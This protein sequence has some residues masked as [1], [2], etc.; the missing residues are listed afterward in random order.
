MMTTGAAADRG[1]ARGSLPLDCRQSPAS[2]P[3]GP[4]CLASPSSTL[5]RSVTYQFRALRAGPLLFNMLGLF[6]FGSRPRGAPRRPANFLGLYFAKWRSGGLL[7]FVNFST[8]ELKE[9]SATD[10][11]YG[12]LNVGQGYD[13]QVCAADRRA[14]RRRSSGSSPGFAR[15]WP[16]SGSTSGVCSRG[17][18]VLVVRH[19]RSSSALRRA[20]ASAAAESPL[21]A[22]RRLTSAA[23]STA[24]V[25]GSSGGALSAVARRA[26]MRAGGSLSAGGAQNARTCT[27][28]T[29]VEFDRVMAKLE[30]QGPGA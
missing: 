22:P 27:R 15:F 14:T 9:G 25:D 26:G 2:R 19:D 8:A 29:A 10:S 16:A 11:N 17:S 28:S 3:A 24:W 12:R 4:S 13:P 7:S 21:R 20:S 6:F 18:R 30:A 23:W 1:E 5:G